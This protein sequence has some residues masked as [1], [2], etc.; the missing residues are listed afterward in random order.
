MEKEDAFIQE[1]QVRPETN[2]VSISDAEVYVNPFQACCGIYTRDFRGH[3][4]GHP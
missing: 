1:W 2:L 3:S 4:V